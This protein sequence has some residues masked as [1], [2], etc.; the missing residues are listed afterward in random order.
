MP[1]SAPG[2]FRLRGVPAFGFAA[3]GLLTGH[4][5]SYLLAVPDPHHRDLLLDRTGHAYLPAAGQVAIVLALAGVAVVV[6]RAWA[7]RRIGSTDRLAPL[8]AMLVGVQVGAFVGQ[9]LLERLVAGASFGDLV[10]DHVLPTGI[11]VQ[12]AVALAGALLL[13][14]LART[15]VRAVAALAGARSP[16]PRPALGTAAVAPAIPP[17]SLALP[18]RSVRAPPSD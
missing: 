4:A 1:T 8:A 10:H 15:S 9:E 13:R 5:I 11:G 7:G 14:W 18:I 17:R 16:L 3:A 12:V 2:S 6:A